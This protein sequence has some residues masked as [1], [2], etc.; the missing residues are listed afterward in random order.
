ME[1]LILRLCIFWASHNI[2]YWNITAF[3][4]RIPLLFTRKFGLTTRTVLVIHELV[5]HGMCVGDD[6]G[7]NYDTSST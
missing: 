1:W 4:R 6:A 7:A 3:F 5:V 2:W